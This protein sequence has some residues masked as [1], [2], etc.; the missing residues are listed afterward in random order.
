MRQ[1]HRGWASCAAVCKEWQASIERENFRRLKLQASCLEKFQSMPIRYRDLVQHICL[2]IEL[3]RYTC[4]SCRYPESY[5]RIYHSIA[6]NT[7]LKLFSALSAWQPR[8]GGRL[9]LELNAY[10]PSDSEHWFKNYHFGLSDGDDDDGD[11]F[12]HQQVTPTWHDPNHGWVS[13]RQVEAPRAPAILRLFS[14]FCVCL[15]K[16]LPEVR[17]VTRLVIR[18]QLRRRILPAA[19]RRLWERLPRLESLVYEPWRGWRH[20]WKIG[21]DRGVCVELS[22]PPRIWIGF[23]LITSQ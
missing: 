16:S 6:R 17:A 1:K 4:R 9:T 14:T 20:A 3:P 12:Q 10:S 21:C 11:L 13:G 5:S 8:T 15:P 18:R 22:R 2:N 23:L 19:L 7:V